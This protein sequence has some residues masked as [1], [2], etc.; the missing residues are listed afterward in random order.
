MSLPD[1]TIKMIYTNYRGETRQRH[2]RPERIW[3]GK[4]D[5]HPEDQ[6]MMT[7]DD[8]ETGNQRDFALRDC[9]FSQPNKP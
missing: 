4:T 8:M 5:W 9:Q 7:A 6:W 2:V 1:C 3:F